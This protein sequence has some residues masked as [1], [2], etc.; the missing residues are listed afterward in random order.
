MGLRVTA[1]P[2][3]VCSAC[4]CTDIVIYWHPNWINE[5]PYFSVDKSWV[6]E[7]LNHPAQSGAAE[8]DTENG[9]KLSN[10]QAACLAGVAWVLL[11]FFPFPV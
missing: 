7:V 1:P 11:S 2:C 9:D 6:Y 4:W 3:T 5:I 8:F 10:S